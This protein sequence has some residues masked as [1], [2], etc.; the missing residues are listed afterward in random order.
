[1]YFKEER[2]KVTENDRRRRFGFDSP[3]IKNENQDFLSIFATRAVDF[4]SRRR[5]NRFFLQN[6]A[7][8]ETSSLRA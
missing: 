7:H 5:K 1:M 8:V 6:S 3:R 2:S 4:Y